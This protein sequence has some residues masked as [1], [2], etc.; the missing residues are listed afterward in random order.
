MAL[1]QAQNAPVET[2]E[3]PIQQPEVDTSK[4]F[5]KGY[6]EGKSKAEKDLVSKIRSL[7]IDD[8]E[9]LDDGISRLAEI[10]QPKKEQVSEVEQLKKMLEEAHKKAESAEG[11]F[12]AF[13]QEMLL[14]GQLSQALTDV[15]SEGSLNLKD[16]HVKNLFYMEYEIEED[17]GQFFATKDGMPMLDRDGNRKQLGTVLKEFI[18]ENGYIKPN[19]VGTGGSTG[20]GVF[21]DKPSRSEFNKLITSKSADAQA[22]AAELYNQYK[23]VGTWGA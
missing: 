21:S 12:H 13:R 10:L 14:E 7:G 23:K 16:D 6:N 11:N 8:V 2:A 3:T 19:V 20:A 22:R 18:R 4:I 17:G 15:K 9:S 5:S 1:E